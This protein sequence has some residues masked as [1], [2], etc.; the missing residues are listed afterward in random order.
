MTGFLPDGV[1]DVEVIR[2][3]AER[4]LT[5]IPVSA[6]YARNQRRSGLLLGFGGS[7]ERRLFEVPRVLG[8]VLQESAGGEP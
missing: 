7:T 8:A 4:G 3:M 1:D 2:R 6:C 5:A